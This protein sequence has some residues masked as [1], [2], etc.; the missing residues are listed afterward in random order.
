MIAFVLGLLPVLLLP[1]LPPPVT[2][3]LLAASGLLLCYWV[4]TAARIYSGLAV[5]CAL[6]LMSAQQLIAH[7]LPESCVGQELSIDGEIASLPRRSQFQ[8]G[9]TRQRFEF[10]VT[11]LSPAGCSGPQRILLSYYGAEKIIPGERWTFA[12]RLSRP[13]GLAN[14]GSFNLQAWYALTGIDAV[15]SVRSG[16]GIK[17]VSAVRIAALPNRMRQHIAERIGSLD[18]SGDAQAVLAAV[19]VAD[20]SGID[21]SLSRL[22]QQFGLNHLLVISGLHVGLVA[23][24]SYLVGGL[25]QRLLLLMGVYA[26]ALPGA[27]AIVACGAYTALAGFSVATQRALCMLLCFIG[28]SL[29]ARHSSS[30]QNLLLAAT[31]VLLVN[32]LAAL[33]SGFWLSFLAVAA[34]LWLGSWQQRRPRCWR[35]LGPHVFMSLVML[36]LGGWWFGGS[37]LVAGLANLL[38]VPVIGLWVVPAALLAVLAL[39][40][41]PLVE[42]PLWQLAAWPLESLLPFGQRLAVNNEWL[43]Q[44]LSSALVDVLLAAAGVAVLVL[45]LSLPGRALALL[46][47]LPLVLPPDIHAAYPQAGDPPGLTRVTVLDVGQGTAV[48]VRGGGRTLVYDTGGGNPV[49]ANMASAVVL[50][51]LRHQGVSA[52]DTLVISHPDNDHSA[53][54]ANLLAVMPP[55]T[56]F[57]GGQMPDLHSARP[58]VSGQAW[59]WPGGQEFQFLSPGLAGAASSNNN[60]CVLQIQ[61]AGHRLLL[62]GDVDKTQERELVRFWASDLASDW[63]LVGHHGSGSSSSHALLKTVNPAIGVISRG[64]ANRFGHPHADVLQ[65]LESHNTSL[66]DTAE[67]GAIEFEFSQG[68]PVKVRVRRQ[69]LRRFWM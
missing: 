14:P 49:G 43:Y 30:A 62:L 23:G 46:L 16:R 40:I 66:F 10:T 55:S 2:G 17:H 58:C 26:S 29:V 8:D 50:P 28:A 69:L 18:I 68:Q 4:G 5:G 51:Y 60:S 3:P 25:L 36:P 61:A 59:R 37:S 38:M 35:W 52:I 22:F 12:V 15:G 65:R 34:L 57:N 54:V 20:K 56:L 33:G 47:L 9:I 39:Y 45:P 6:A 19:T 53:G 41:F 11:R 31:V 42:I 24:A 1:R 13:W 67:G 48:I 64:Y 27:L 63:I 21:A 32:P 44:H 7:K